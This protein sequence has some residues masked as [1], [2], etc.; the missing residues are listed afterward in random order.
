VVDYDEKK[1]N[2]GN[3]LRTY[4]Q[5]KQSPSEEKYLTSLPT[6]TDRRYVTLPN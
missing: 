6:K 1:T 3:K 4:R 2:Y 5:F